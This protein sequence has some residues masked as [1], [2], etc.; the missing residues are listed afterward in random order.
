MNHR[1]NSL[2]AFLS[3]F[4]SLFYRGR[5]QFGGNKKE[6]KTKNKNKNKITTKDKKQEVMRIHTTITRF[7]RLYS[8]STKQLKKK[9]G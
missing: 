2:S 5:N 4:S 9:I 3:L 8:I 6:K 7:K 1:E